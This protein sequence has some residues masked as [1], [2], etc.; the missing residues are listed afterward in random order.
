MQHRGHQPDYLL[1]GIVVVLLLFGFIVLSSASTPIAYQKFNQPYYFVIH[2]IV[3]GL[4]PGVALFFFFSRFHYTKL[5]QLAWPLLI[6]SIA[7]LTLVFIPGLGAEYGSAKSWITILGFSVQPA[8]IVKLTFLI[9][10]AA[11][12]DGRGE[13]R[14]QDLHN[15]FLP[16]AI[17]LG[18]ISVLMLLQPD[19][20]TLSIIVITAVIMYFVGG[21]SLKHLGII[22]A[23]GLAGFLALVKIAPYRMDRFTAFLHPERDPQGIAYHI[24]QSLIA[25]GSGGFFGVGLGHSRQKFSYLPEVTGDSIFAIIGEELGFLF[26]TAFIGLLL[27]FAHR[28]FVLAKNTPD[29]FSRLLVIGIITWLIFQSFINIMGMLSLLPMTGIPLPF[30]SAGGT[31]LMTSLAAV[32]I[33]LNISR[34]SKI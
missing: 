13:K 21:G 23:V 20:G 16:F 25:V 5:K 15:S 9:Y 30:I 1:L 7:L 24:W 22:G 10:L 29:R 34:F 27:F 31:A 26:T 11:W 8:E 19:L 12:L 3:T 4:L 32:G 14:V 18:I 6:F 33:L 28:G 17:V 2:Q